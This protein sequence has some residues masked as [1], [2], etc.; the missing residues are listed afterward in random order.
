MRA[1]AFRDDCMRPPRLPAI[2]ALI[3]LHPAAPAYAEVYKCTDAQGRITYTND[4]TLA[5]GCKALDSGQPVSTVPAPPRRA[6]TPPRPAAPAASSSAAAGFPQVSPADQRGRDQSRR[7]LLEA[8]LA[9]EQDALQAAEAALA[10]QEAIRL[11][12][13]RNYQKVLDR[14][15][16][17]RSRVDLH[18][19]NIDA[20]RGEIA[21]LR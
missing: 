9:S 6:A 3:V 5:R 13:E 12:D 10:E 2:F 15:Q 4:R 8:E 14:L 17:F 19:R 1:A 7:Q 18:K 11:G 20:L 16:P 21:R